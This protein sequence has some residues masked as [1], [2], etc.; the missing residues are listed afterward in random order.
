MMDMLSPERLRDLLRYEP[1]TGKLFWR[2][3]RPEQFRASSGRTVEHVCNNWNAI[4]SG[5]EALTADN[6]NGY[7]VGAI[8]RRKYYAHRVAWAV[9]HGEHPD[10]IDHIN[11]R[12]DDNRIANLR[13]VTDTENAR[14]CRVS[15]NNASGVNGVSW[16]RA[17]NKWVATITI[18]RRAYYLGAFATIPEATEARRRAERGVF[19]ENHGRG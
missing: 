8:F 1:E 12:R 11:G 3:R 6:G 2:E 7:R 17:V 19:H 15:K 10:K 4:H 13:S 16:S 9:F 5:A 18:D 14:N